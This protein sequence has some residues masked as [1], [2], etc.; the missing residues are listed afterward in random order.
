M[1]F[2]NSL[3]TE[4]SWNILKELTKKPVEF[5]LIGG[6]AA[7]LWTKLHKSKDIDIIVDINNLQYFKENY[8]LIKNDRLKKYEVKFQEIDL[9]IYVPH[10]SKLAIPVEDV[11]EHITK[12]Q[13][14]KVVVPEVLL[15]LK[16]GAE[17]E[18]RESVKGGKDRVDIMTLIFYTDIDFE[19]YSSLLKR[20]KLA[21]YYTRLKEIINSFREIEYLGLNPREFKL[22]K[23]EA[24]EKLR[25]LK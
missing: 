18:R 13:N 7:Y 22:R 6:W 15:I 8:N 9:D 19:K 3:L 1:E 4:K 14:I 5:T 21:D 2:W 25:F 16:Q 10:Y 17:I 23:K 24:L 20:Y 11:L 12:I